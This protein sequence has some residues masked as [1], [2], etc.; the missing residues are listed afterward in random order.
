MRRKFITAEV[1]GLTRPG[2]SVRDSRTL[3]NV[4]DLATP[5]TAPSTTLDM[6]QPAIT[7]GAAN[8]LTAPSTTLEMTE[9]VTATEGTEPVTVPAL[10]HELTALQA[11]AARH[12]I[13]DPKFAALGKQIEALLE[14]RPTLPTDARQLALPQLVS[15]VGSL[16]TSVLDAICEAETIKALSMAAVEAL[17]QVGLLDVT[18]EEIDG[19]VT[20]TGRDVTGRSA[21]LELTPSSVIMD[22]DAPADAVHPLHPEAGD[23]CE[24]AAA[25]AK[26]LETVMPRVFAD[27]GL[28]IGDVELIEPPTRG[29]SP[30][31]RRRNTPT[32]RDRRTL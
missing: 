26:D 15:E 21:E 5:V 27:F 4:N 16:E 29:S 13:T 31:F 14:E 32:P 10:N 3:I 12:G 9:T 6:T 7:L 25:L 11:V 28:Q 8:L 20:V 1:R 24:G 23:I 19:E 17:R 22:V 30:K 18:V 2:L